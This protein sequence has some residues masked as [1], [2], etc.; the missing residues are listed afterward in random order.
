[1]ACP[2]AAWATDH[3]DGDM[4]VFATP[5]GMTARRSDDQ[6]PPL[7]RLL[8]GLDP[9]SAHL[10]MRIRAAR[11]GDGL[12]TWP[13]DRPLSSID[14]TARFDG[15]AFIIESTTTDHTRGDLAV[16]ETLAFDGHRAFSRADHSPG[17]LLVSHSAPLPAEMQH[18]GFLDQSGRWLVDNLAD[19]ASLSSALAS[20]MEI[21]RTFDGGAVHV[22]FVRTDAEGAALPRERFELTIEPDPMH[23]VEVDVSGATATPRRVR[24]GNLA[25]TS[26]SVEGGAVA[27]ETRRQ[28]MHATRW[29]DF[30]G[31]SLPASSEHRL[32]QWQPNGRV[33]SSR[34]DFRVID[35]HL[36]DPADVRREIAAFAEPRVGETVFE[37]DLRLQFRVGERR[38]TLAGARYEAAMPL[39]TIPVESVVDLVAAARRVDGGTRWSSAPRREPDL[40]RTGDLRRW[41]QLGFGAAFVAVGVWIW[42]RA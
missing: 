23:A 19:G 8:D 28:Q 36:A 41:I 14:A 26:F 12:A 22:T 38:F 35:A 11:F 13:A 34:V 30:D 17:W 7:A 18:L 24:I 2:C 6:G 40:D 4:V 15:D 21:G 27:S 25:A 42:R 29:D 32:E 37:T 39:Q 16:T 31:I 3:R 5:T 9:R 20:G 33:Q 10:A 1:M